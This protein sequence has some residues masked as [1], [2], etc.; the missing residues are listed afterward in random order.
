MFTK[1]QIVGTAA[2]FLVI[3]FFGF[4]LNRSGKPYHPLLFN[5]HKLIALAA[6]AFL[7]VTVYRIHQVAPLST[8]ALAAAIVTTVLF[9][10]NIVA[11]GLLNIETDMPAFVSW[12]HKV[13]PYLIVLSTAAT[14]YLLQGHK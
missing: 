13:T 12:I 2:F 10:L 4:W 7:I 1:L 9:A 11:G 3:F 6:L 8:A 5:I 14:I